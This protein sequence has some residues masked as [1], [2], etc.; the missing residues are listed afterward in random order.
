MLRGVLVWL[1]VMGLET[2]H[3]TLRGLFL[4]PRVGLE[5][6]S[7]IG[8]P[9]GLVIVYVT[10]WAAARFVGLRTTGALLGLGA[11]W[12]VLT[13]AFEVGIGFARGL[14]RAAILA[15]INPLAGG[16]MVYSLAAMFLAP[17]VA[18][19]LRGVQRLPSSGRPR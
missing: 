8:W 18:A 11:L 4:V 16:L 9:V 14:D 12:A 2:V 6:A 13:F 5:A 7:R 19:R 15:E 1:L 10:A 3:G 17:L